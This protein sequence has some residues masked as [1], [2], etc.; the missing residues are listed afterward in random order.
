[1]LHGANAARRI[2]AREISGPLLDIFR[3]DPKYRPADWRG[4]PIGPRP[5]PAAPSATEPVTLTVDD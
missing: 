4:R 1:M 3:D 2:L 5:H